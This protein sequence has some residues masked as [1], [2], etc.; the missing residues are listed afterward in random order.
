MPMAAVLYP[1][2]IVFALLP[3]PWAVRFYTVA[4]VAV[5]WAGTFAL[6][7]TL[8]LSATAAGLAALGYAFGAPLLFQYCNIIYLVGAAWIPCGFLAVEWLIGQQRRW[9]LPALALVLGL[10]VLGG[11]PE[12]A[13]VT[14]LCGVA[15]ALVRSA[16][17]RPESAQRRG[18]Y[19]CLLLL[20]GWAVTTLGVAYAAPRMTAP[21]WLPPRAILLGLGWGT[22]GLA[23]VWRWRQRGRGARLGPCLAVLCCASVLALVLAAAQ[24]LPAWEYA[25]PTLRASGDT[26]GRIYGFCVEPY[27]LLE[28]VWPD[29]WGRF[30]PENRSWVQALPPAGERLL[31]TPSLY[32]GGLTLMLAGAGLGFSHR[33]G[34]GGA[35]AWRTWL[36][37]VAICAVAAGLG[38]F[39][40]PLWVARWLPGVSAVLGPHDPPQPL[41]RVDAFLDDG[42]GS[43]YGL[44]A[45]VL[46]GFSLFRYPA[47]LMPF[48]ALALAVLAGLG[49]ERLEAGQTRMP[50][51]W[52]R[53]GLAVTLAALLLIMTGRGP[54]LTW[55]TRQLP[56]GGEFGPVDPRAALAATVRGLVH[57][58]LVLALGLA[59]CRLAPRLPRCAGVV[60]LLGMTLDLGIA[61][62]PLV[63]TIPQADLE[64]TP[65][66]LT[67]IKEAQADEE[68]SMPGPFRVHRMGMV[69]PGGRARDT[70][71][72]RLRAAI[73]WERDTLDPLLGLPLGLEYTLCP[74]VLDR[75]NYALFFGGGAAAPASPRGVASGPYLYRI[76]RSGYSLWN[77]RYVIMPVSSNGWIGINGGL[78]RL[79][80]PSE[81]VADAEQA[82]RWIA[83]Q[84]WQL[85]CN[86]NAHPRA[87][88]VH[89]LFVRPPTANPNDPGQL[90]LM[91][92]LVY[93]TDPLW[94]EPGSPLLDLRAIAFV[95]TD[96]PRTLAGTSSRTGVSPGESVTI[97]RSE[98]QHVEL[99]AELKR[100]GLVILADAY[101]PGWSLTIDG[102]PAPI[103]RTN[104][105]MRG[106]AVKAGRHTLAYTYN[107]ASF[108]IGAGLS[109]VGLLALIA[110]VPWAWHDPT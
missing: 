63:W 95:E 97:T 88:L 5:A 102:A 75:D 19:R 79:Y 9:G 101:D 58:G 73:A 56:A 4:H 74:S 15:Y 93:Q 22:V 18:R 96:Q 3:Y 99:A 59:L 83:E 57:G 64:T 110:L 36:S 27:R 103:F 26:P 72:E 33:P 2:K 29:A 105:L 44:M 39:G 11:D 76:P 107:P 70:T 71:K 49:W 60:A 6:G 67:L 55:L 12:S 40:G 16:W 68:F 100:P 66:A 104:R 54:I 53:T 21:D 90:E 25:A 85:L 43:V 41:D 91:K 20:V 52:S 61:N 35:P 62:A 32:I 109:I 23:V 69:A 46:P 94:R 14:V 51:R 108:R 34:D 50:Q 17:D 78:E 1:G 98:P 84:D 38:R 42:A 45:W 82:R 65:R 8:R 24:L 89:S 13:Y 92:D 30:G 10:Q 7:R 37:L 47:K 48:A 28:A 106:A 87:W 81:V 77:S 31:W 80:P 86:R